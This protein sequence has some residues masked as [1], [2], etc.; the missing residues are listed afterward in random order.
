M[1]SNIKAVIFDLDGTL[2]DTLWEIREG[3]N[4]TRAE[5]GLPPA[6]YD[7]VKNGLNVG[8]RHL[9]KTTVADPARAD[10]EE[11]INDVQRRYVA[12]Y[13]KVFHKTEK[14]YDGVYETVM[15]LKN[16]GIKLAVLSNKPDQFVKVLS[17]K[18][19]GDDTFCVLRGPVEGGAR[20][21]DPALTLEVLGCISKDIKPSECAFVGD[22]NVDIE[23]AKNAGMY[24]VAVTWGYRDRAFLEKYIP[25]MIIDSPDELLK[26]F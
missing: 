9:V 7:D 26:L 25:D 6:S 17:A 1:S 4:N 19:L 12:A 23:T 14:P 18:L 22:S 21:P 8:V 20:K 3:V 2:A 10:D 16:K 5:L 11:Y 15:A 13:G 24:S